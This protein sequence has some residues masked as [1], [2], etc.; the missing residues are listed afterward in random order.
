MGGQI[1]SEWSEL[2]SDVFCFPNVVVFSLSFLRM[3]FTHDFS[4]DSHDISLN[5]RA[6]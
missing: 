5:F 2:F 4:L 1:T 6:D 3:I